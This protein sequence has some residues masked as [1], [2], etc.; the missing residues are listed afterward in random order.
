M[1]YDKYYINNDAPADNTTNVVRPMIVRR[2]EDIKARNPQ[3]Q[4]VE[5]QKANIRAER[6]QR[7]S[8]TFAKTPA[9]RR[10]ANRAYTIESQR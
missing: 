2:N 9:G 7:I 4:K 5:Q 8:S 10:A 1:E 3:R 6:N